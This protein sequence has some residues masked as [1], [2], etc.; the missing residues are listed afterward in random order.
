MALPHGNA[1]CVFEKTRNTTLLLAD[2]L[3]APKQVV[4]FR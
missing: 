3:D 4:Y 1:I 2:D